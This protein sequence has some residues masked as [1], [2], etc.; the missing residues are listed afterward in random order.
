MP[1]PYPEQFRSRAIALLRAEGPPVNRVA[2]RLGIAESGLR[3]W[4]QRHDVDSGVCVGFDPGRT[5][6]A[7]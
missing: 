7:R 6:G 5:Q 1:T 4:L 3:R 2:R